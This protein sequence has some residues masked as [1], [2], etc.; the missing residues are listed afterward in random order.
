MINHA[1]IYIYIYGLILAGENHDQ[2]VL[3]TPLQ[4]WMALNVYPQVTPT[5][6]WWFILGS[7]SFRC[8][9]V[10]CYETQCYTTI[11]G[12]SSSTV[13]LVRV[14]FRWVLE[15]VHT[16]ALAFLLFTG[17][18]NN[19]SSERWRQYHFLIKSVRDFGVM[20]GACFLIL[21]IIGTIHVPVSSINVPPPS[22]L[23]CEAAA[24]AFP[25]PSSM[26]PNHGLIL[27]CVLLTL[28]ALSIIN[29]LRPGHHYYIFEVSITLAMHLTLELL[30]NGPED[31]YHDLGVFSG[32]FIFIIIIIKNF[33]W[34]N[35]GNGSQSRPS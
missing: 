25:Q 26:A 21:K 18:H 20:L 10:T 31:P 5:R 29:L 30:V 15:I 7:I 35:V 16:V 4:R 19:P 33:I 22:S 3:P 23:R 13:V 12:C 2:E 11:V 34:R 9:L 27:T 14:I 6:I 1:Y 32:L 24:H 17:F 28:D 8:A